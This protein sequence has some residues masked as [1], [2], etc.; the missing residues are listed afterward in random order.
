[1]AP[2]PSKIN[3]NLNPIRSPTPTL[4]THRCMYLQ[5]L[6]S[7]NNTCE[8]T[9][10]QKRCALN[11]FVF[12]HTIAHKSQNFISCNKMVF[13]LKILIH[14]RHQLQRILCDLLQHLSAQTTVT[15]ATICLGNVHGLVRKP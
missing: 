8:L 1:M 6:Q 4:D 10:L 3:H 5:N 14:Q 11:V 13:F 7:Q 2:P 15:L 12:S 9:A